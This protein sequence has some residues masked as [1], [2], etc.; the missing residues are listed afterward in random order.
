MLLAELV[1]TSTAVAATRSRKAKVAAL[2]ETLRGVEPAE[3]EV[4]VSY[5]GGALRQRRTGLGWRGV[6]DLPVPRRRADPDGARGARGVRGDVRPVRRGLAAR[7]ASDAVDELFGRATADEQAWL[8]GR[9]H[10]QR[11]PGRARR[12]VPGGRRAGGRR[13]ARGR[14]PR[15]DARR[16]HGRG[17]RGRVRGRGGAGRDRARGRPA[18]PAD[19]RL[20]RARRRRGD[21]RPVRRTA[22]PRSRS[23]PSSTASGSRCTATA[24]TCSSRPAAST[25][26]PTGCPRWSRSR[27]RCRP[28][29]SSSTAR[30]WR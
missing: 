26:S 13:A 14:T 25:T 21:G 15:R 7:R 1:A 6:S 23:T 4:V 8:R 2:A 22:R 18:G 24:T 27:G 11:P 12:L 3:L 9:R 5:L 30:R 10:R 17:R 20:Q 19:A 29:G 28:P 16:Q